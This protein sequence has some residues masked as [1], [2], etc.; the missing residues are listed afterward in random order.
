[1]KGFTIFALAVG[2]ASSLIIIG[3]FVRSMLAEAK[4][5]N[6]EKVEG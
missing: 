2:T 5:K 6:G 4:P 1:M 3:Q